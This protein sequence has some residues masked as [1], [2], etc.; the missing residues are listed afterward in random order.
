M[1]NV[2]HNKDKTYFLNVFACTI[3][4]NKMNIFN[5][6]ILMKQKIILNIQKIYLY[7]KIQNKR[8]QEINSKYLVFIT[9][10]LLFHYLIT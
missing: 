5:Q 3:L 2:F 6:N 8:Y 9:L 7:L 4:Y 1:A 10:F